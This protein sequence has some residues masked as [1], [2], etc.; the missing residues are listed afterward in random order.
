M[1]HPAMLKRILD[2]L[3]QGLQ[4]D[5][6]PERRREWLTPALGGRL[7]R[8]TL[9][10][11][12]DHLDPD[13][14]WDSGAGSNRSLVEADSRDPHRRLH[15]AL[16]DHR[17]W[18]KRP[19][20]G[21][22][23]R[24][25]LEG[26]CFTDLI[27]G[28]PPTVWARDLAEHDGQGAAV[29]AQN[30]AWHHARAFPEAQDRPARCLVRPRPGLAS[31]QIEC[32]FGRGVYLPNPTA[33]P[34]FLVLPALDGDPVVLPPLAGARETGEITGQQPAAF[35]ADQETLLLSAGA[36]GPVGLPD[37]QAPAGHYL[38]LQRSG[39]DAW[40]A[41]G[42]DD[43][44]L[45]VRRGPAG[46][47]LIEL[48][49][50]AGQA[51]ALELR[52]HRTGP[53]VAGGSTVL[54]GAAA[55]TRPETLALMGIILP[56]LAAGLRRWT[57]WLDADGNLASAEQVARAEPG[58]IALELD[59]RGL[60]LCLPDAAPE[61]LG[62]AIESPRPFAGAELCRAPLPGQPGLLRLSRHEHYPLAL[63]AR[64]LGRSDPDGPAPDI[65]LDQLAQ[66][67]ALLWAGPDPGI[68]LGNLGLSRRHAE[69][70]VED[71]QLRAEP[72][73]D[74]CLLLHLDPDLQPRP[75]TAPLRLAPGDH[76]VAGPF[77]LR[78]CDGHPPPGPG[79]P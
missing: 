16:Q 55:A 28:L 21:P 36:D 29:L 52:A 15:R 45:P 57:L 7:W 24:Q 14:L 9:A 42:P 76:L 46:A 65:A 78:Y 27:I 43:R 62:R 66:P 13:G 70:W 33:E 50:A 44:E 5:R 58:L 18:L 54:P 41:R 19:E 6:A 23:G 38:L 10:G 12:T 59:Q 47:W 2:P 63:E 71:G 32:L 53:A 68:G 69:V 51:L 3:R 17:R 73:K 74:G 40:Q 60:R 79:A 20:A 31:D 75:A 8:L 56:P 1:H 11:V 67:D 72:V 34:A 39:P 22:G 25:V 61:P 35:Y 4:A 77:L 64:S 37:W 26:R 48:R 30:L 49:P